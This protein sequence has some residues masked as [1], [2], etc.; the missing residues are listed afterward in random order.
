MEKE[1]ATIKD[2]QKLQQELYEQ[3]YKKMM[4]V[5]LRYA[6]DKDEAKDILHEGFIKVFNKIDQFDNKGS[7]EGWIR[8]VIVNTAIDHCRTTIH[9]TSLNENYDLTEEIEEDN[10]LYEDLSAEEIMQM[11]QS[12]SPVYRT[13]FN[14][15]AIENYS[16]KEIAEKLGISEGTSKSNLSKARMSLKKMFFEHKKIEA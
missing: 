13:V 9:T 15:Y 7:L 16:H 14:M 5:C 11:I 10:E 12:L 3:H 8:R 2:K 6:M 1:K 4:G